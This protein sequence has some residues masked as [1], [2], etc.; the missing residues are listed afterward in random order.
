MARR[1]DP[2][3]DTDDGTQ[4]GRLGRALDQFN[5]YSGGVP[6]STVKVLEED[7]SSDKTKDGSIPGRCYTEIHSEIN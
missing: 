1:K 4:F 5:G 2:A 6:A 3:S 7:C